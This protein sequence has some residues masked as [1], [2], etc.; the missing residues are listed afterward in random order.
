MSNVWGTQ[1]RLYVE[2]LEAIADRISENQQVAPA[3]AEEQAVRLLVTVARL[4]RQHEVNQR[5]Q[6]NFCCWTRWGWRLWRRRP[7]CTVFRAAGFALGQ[8]L[9]VVWWQVFEVFDRNTS[10][11]EVREWVA[12]R[13]PGEPTPGADEGMGETA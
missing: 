4:L 6:C 7:Q 13:W 3:V 2:E 9:D 8:P 11:A 12:Q 1:Y 10:L 5:G